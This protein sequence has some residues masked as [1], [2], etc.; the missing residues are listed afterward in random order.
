MKRNTPR[1]IAT[2]TTRSTWSMGR[3]RLFSCVDDDLVVRRL[4]RMAHT[5]VFAMGGGLPGLGQPTA[6]PHNLSRTRVYPAQTTLRT[7]ASTPTTHTPI[8]TPIP[9]HDAAAEAACGSV[10]QVHDSG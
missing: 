10:A 7:P 1:L 5:S 6:F 4:P 3:G 9:R 2:M 8:A